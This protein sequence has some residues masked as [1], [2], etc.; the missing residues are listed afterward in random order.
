MEMTVQV[1]FQQ[2]IEW[3]KVL[4]P[5]E[6]AIL[7]KELEEEK[8]IRKNEKAIQLLL[9][10]PIFTEEDIARIEQTRKSINKWRRKDS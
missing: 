5:S 3:V 10:S 6:K 4:T 2:L 8:S 1:P 9:D 7:K